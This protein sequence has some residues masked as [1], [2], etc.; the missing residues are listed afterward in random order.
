M[1]SLFVDRVHEIDEFDSLL[2]DIARGRKRHVALL[3]L[4]RI[5]KTVLLAEVQKRH[6]EFP[7]VYLALDE[8][9]S[10]PEDFARALLAQTLQVAALLRGLEPPLTQSDEDLA[11]LAGTLHPKLVPLVDEV[12]GLAG[13]GG[14]LRRAAGIPNGLPLPAI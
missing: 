11:G 5:G 14:E 7:I 1:E 8:T 13:C 2:S 4:R 9:V 3:G 6:P 10:N 12:L